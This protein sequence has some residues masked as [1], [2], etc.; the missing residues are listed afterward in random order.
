MDSNES[1]NCDKLKKEAYR[2]LDNNV[3]EG[4][5][6][7]LNKDYFY[8][9]PD[10]EHYHQWLWD[11]CFH[12]IV[13]ADYKPEYS[14]KEFETLLSVQQDNGFIPHIIFWEWREIDKK[15]KW[16]KKEVQDEKTENFTSE[17]Q[18]PV[19]GIT[20]YHMFQKTGN[21]PFIEKH[22]D[23][24]EKFYH[25][26]R[27]FR[28]PDDDNLV[29]I[30]TPMESGMDLSPQY[31]IPL[32][33]GEFK[34]EKSKLHINKLLK[35][36]K[37][38][39]WDTKKIFK[40]GSFNVEDVS[41]NSIYAA[42]IKSLSHLYGE[43][44]NQDK[45][46]EMIEWY[47][48][49]LNSIIEK[50]WDENQGIF[51]SL[52]HNEGYESQIKIKTISSLFPIILDIPDKMSSSL[53]DHIKNE[54][55]FNCRYPVP[56]VSLDEPSF[57]PLTDTRYLWRGTTWINSN[58]FIAA[59]LKKHGHKEEFEKLQERTL[60]LVSKEGFHEF[61][62]PFDGHPGHAMR[63]FGWSTLAIEFCDS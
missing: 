63:N 56:S 30:I 31:D 61:Y 1:F 62:D 53:V 4:F 5:N 11:S 27:D 6:E 29:S 21:K 57:G 50:M 26:L 20:L 55:E 7:K 38:L 42:G 25:Y 13:N 48:N 34:P 18:P 36:H 16:W 22:I 32:G 47:K 24:V 37:N 9:S 44:G 28:D 46:E 15:K 17:I 19:P 23:K 35:E 43:L 60:K 33:N 3:K 58:W 45:A 14:F 51:F 54:E 40:K 2:V 49:V 10:M 12:C 41:F 52:N 39:N 8:L 59:G